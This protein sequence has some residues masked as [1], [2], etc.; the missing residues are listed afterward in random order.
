MDAASSRHGRVNL[1]LGE[2]R[3]IEVLNSE[4]RW[5]HQNW[6]LV[7][8]SSRHLSSPSQISMQKL[9]EIRE[10]DPSSVQ[11]NWAK[12]GYSHFVWY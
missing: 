11:I 3:G 8:K 9:G 1:I 7:L 12:T 4:K 2:V 6:P 5:R 10:I